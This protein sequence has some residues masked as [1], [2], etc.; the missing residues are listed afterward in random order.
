MEKRDVR[1]RRRNVNVHR[2]QGIFERFNQNLG[3]R[4]F[5]FQYSQEMNFTSSSKRSAEG[6]KRLQ[7]WS[8]LL[9]LKGEK[10]LHE[11]CE[12]EGVQRRA[13]DPIWPLKVFNIKRSIVDKGEPV[14]YFLKDGAKHGFARNCSS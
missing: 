9:I 8:Q 7:K 5:S 4:F 13:A 1:N 6:V 14:F 3:K 11:E 12:L 10:R 2:D